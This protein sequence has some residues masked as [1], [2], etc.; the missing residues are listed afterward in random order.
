[1]GVFLSEEKKAHM[2]GRKERKGGGGAGGERRGKTK[3][4][5][6]SIKLGGNAYAWDPVIKSIKWSRW[7]K[8]ANTEIQG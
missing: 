3:S 7:S 8:E 5:E 4:P 6:D 1:M 2:K